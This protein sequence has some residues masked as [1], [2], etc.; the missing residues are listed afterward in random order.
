MSSFSENLCEIYYMCVVCF[1]MMSAKRPIS[2]LDSPILGCTITPQAV[3]VFA[4]IFQR[5]INLPSGVVSSDLSAAPRNVPRNC[6]PSIPDSASTRA[7]KEGKQ[8]LE[9]SW[10]NPYIASWL[11]KR[12]RREDVNFAD[13][14]ALA[15]RTV[16]QNEAITYV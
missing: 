6:R 12:K 8:P 1:N 10:L 7:G 5:L 14:R 3:H 13:A 2:L 9:I 4:W 11:I 16:S 15:S